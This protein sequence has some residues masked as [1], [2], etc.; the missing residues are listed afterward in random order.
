MLCYAAHF[1]PENGT[2]RRGKRHMSDLYKMVH[3]ER[4]RVG[5]R[6]LPQHVKRLRPL[7]APPA[8]TRPL[9][10]R[11]AGPQHQLCAPPTSG[12]APGFC[13]SGTD[14]TATP[15]YAR[16]RD[17]PGS[18][19]T[20]G[21]N[22]SLSLPRGAPTSDTPKRRINCRP[23]Q[24][25]PS[26]HTCPPQAR[27]PTEPW[28]R[29]GGPLLPLPCAAARPRGQAATSSGW[30][31]CLPPATKVPPAAR[32]RGSPRGAGPPLRPGRTRGS[33]A[34]AHFQPEQS[35]AP[36]APFRPR[37]AGLRTP[38]LCSRPNLPLT[39]SGSEGSAR[40][41]GSKPAPAL[42]QTFQLALVPTTSEPGALAGARGAGGPRADTHRLPA[43]SGPQPP[44]WEAASQRFTVERQ[45]ELHDWGGT[46]GRPGGQTRE[47]RGQ[48]LRAQSGA[49][50]DCA[51][52]PRQ[53]FGPVPCR[54]SYSLYGWRNEGAGRISFQKDQTPNQELSE[55]GQKLSWYYKQFRT[56]GPAEDLQR[57]ESPALNVLLCNRSPL[58]PGSEAMCCVPDGAEKRSWE[59]GRRGKTERRRR[60]ARGTPCS[61]VTQA[62]PLTYAISPRRA[63]PRRWE[64]LRP[65]RAAVGAL[66]PP[67]LAM[68]P[69]RGL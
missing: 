41:A 45:V 53:L 48:R 55:C 29:A 30:G 38:T 54:W 47:Q 25:S 36:R 65:A 7:P 67:A 64:P 33:R 57:A 2:G 39:R 27:F 37:R 43:G 59:H 62:P 66:S 22:S 23:I 24:G 14:A 50:A 32:G 4:G 40:P 12:P 8:G 15:G 44:G 42:G 58:S 13:P 46:G 28:V 60:R 31:H 20:I 11:T 34:P 52:T 21:P 1:V 9:T 49:G 18:P 17:R 19:L 63:A 56:P 16:A 6:S 35:A 69:A 51:A 3:L 26:G 10:C 61:A 68:A 5:A